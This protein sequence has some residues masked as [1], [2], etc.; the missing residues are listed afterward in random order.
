MLCILSEIQCHK[1]I[2]RRNIQSILWQYSSDGTPSATTRQMNITLDDSIFTRYVKA[3]Q[4]WMI[5]RF[6]L[7]IHCG[8]S[9]I[10]QWSANDYWKQTTQHNAWH[11]GTSW[12][13]S[14]SM[15]IWSFWSFLIL[16]IGLSTQVLKSLISSITNIRCNNWYKK[17]GYPNHTLQIFRR[18]I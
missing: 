3:K 15:D 4:P 16:M 12:T 5:R 2:T 18:G 1:V 11:Q 13:H 10:K 6:V 9:C 17:R 7:S 14:E 8:P